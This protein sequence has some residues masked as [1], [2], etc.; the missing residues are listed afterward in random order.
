MNSTRIVS[1]MAL[2]SLAL[3]AITSL[4]RQTF[5]HQTSDSYIWLT[6]LRIV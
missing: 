3:A 5:K 1:I 6:R 4:W 2:I